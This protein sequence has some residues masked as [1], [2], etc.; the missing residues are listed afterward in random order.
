MS[1]IIKSYGD[2]GLQVH[3]TEIDVGCPS[4]GGTGWSPR[5]VQQ[6]DVYRNALQACVDDNP[7]VCTAFLS[8]GITDK[9]T[10]LGTE[11]HP[12][13]F[14]QNYNKKPA[15]TKMVNVLKAAIQRRE[16]EEAEEEQ[17][18][19]EEEERREQEEAEEEQRRQEEAEEEQQES[20][21]SE[22]TE[23]EEDDEPED[24]SDEQDSDL[25]YDPDDFIFA[26]RTR[27]LKNKPMCTGC[28]GNVGECRWSYPIGDPERAQSKDKGWR[29]KPK[30]TFGQP[31]NNNV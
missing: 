7:G 17:R 25:E 27:N 3:I 14:D 15:Y 31:C 10:W 29:C 9:Y 26:R 21:E 13:P 30:Y 11:A 5:N 12:L 6:A 23:E 2:L 8:W 16:Q 22:E 28:L 18:R 20:E 4:C 1:D 24:E 19:Q